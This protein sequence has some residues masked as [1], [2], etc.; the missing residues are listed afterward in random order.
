MVPLSIAAG[1]TLI[2]IEWVYTKNSVDIGCFHVF[3]FAIIWPAALVLV[4][5]ILANAQRTPKPHRVSSMLVLHKAP[6]LKLSKYIKMK[7]S[8]NPSLRALSYRIH[9]KGLP[10]YLADLGHVEAV[11]QGAGVLQDPC[12]LILGSSPYHKHTSFTVSY[13]YQFQQCVNFK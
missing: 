8:N 6:L 10:L 3:P 9:S 7:P 12:C 4:L 5:R 11:N 13:S 2:N 1:S